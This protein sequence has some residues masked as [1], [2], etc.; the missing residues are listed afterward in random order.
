MIFARLVDED[1]GIHQDLFNINPLTDGT[2]EKVLTDMKLWA[3]LF[4][5]CDVLKYSCI[6]TDGAK[7]M[8]WSK[9]FL[10]GLL[11]ENG[12]KWITLHCTIHHEALCGKAMKLM[13]VRQNVVRWSS[14]TRGNKSPTSSKI[15]G[16]FGGDRCWISGLASVCEYQMI[17]HRQ[18]AETF[19]WTAQRNSFS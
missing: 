14:L 8:V 7:V 15:R 17:E 9:T 4:S 10:V 5:S 13:E 12:R 16:I 19:L 1:F 3:P 11:K 2:N 18:G 6:L